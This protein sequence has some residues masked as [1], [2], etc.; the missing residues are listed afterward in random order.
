VEPARGRAARLAAAAAVFAT[1]WAARAEAFG[2][3]GHE[4][5]E[6]TAYKRLMALDAV[7]GTGTPAVSGRTVLATLIATNVLLPPPCFDRSRW[8]P[9]CDDDLRLELPLR[10]W[11]LL[12]AGAPDLVIDR[13]LG[14]QG[15]CQHF[16]ARTDDGTSAVDPRFG[17]PGD[18]VTTA[19]DR[20]VRIVGLAYDGILTN[21]T[22]ASW[23]LVGTYALIHALEDSFSA[24]HVDRDAHF[25]IVHLL[26]WTLID[27]P[28]NLFTGKRH[29]GYAAPTHHAVTDARDYE[30]LEQDGSAH[31]GKP[32]KSFLH[33]YAVPEECLTPRAL[34]AVDAVFDLL[35]MTYRIRVGPG[36]QARPA[37]ILVDSEAR[38]AWQGYLDEHFASVAA[39]AE[40]PREPFTQTK[41]R[42][43]WFLG[44]HVGAGDGAWAAGVW[45]AH[46][47]FVRPVV[48]FALVNSGGIIYSRVHGASGL[49][50]VY[51]LGLALPLVRR[52]TIG[53]S[54]IGVAVGC[55]T[56]VSDCS[57]DLTAGV[58]VLLIPLGDSTWLGLEGPRYSWID[59]RWSEVWAAVAFGWSYEDVPHPRTFAPDA[60][61]AWNPPRPDEV[62]AY[63]GA[64][65]TRTLHVIASVGSRDDD[66]Y[67]GGAVGLRRDRDAW[68][69]R[70][71]LCPELELA[72]FHGRVDATRN[73]GVV[74]VAPSLR[75]Y[76]VA[77]K[78]SLVATPALM[79]A[80]AL[81]SGKV[82]FDLGAR[83]GIAL[84]LERVELGVDSAPLSYLSDDLRHAFPLA[85][86]IGALLD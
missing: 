24:A 10:H 25:K 56:H 7:P 30:Y 29:V 81:G 32:C 77:D 67:F 47:G 53:A 31:G 75:T 79:R 20:C 8:S 22:R 54:P 62:H 80:G 19:Y 73:A 69:Q 36:G 60:A 64:R 43:D 66:A 26:S 51:T 58:G 3:V 37:S 83:A 45:G 18:L 6:A 48:P 14:Q 55:N 46:L 5:I 33:P 15:Q 74:S 11:P 84:Q 52:F 1:L 72:L 16:M 49:T 68:N 71:G 2:L 28:R 23:R 50:G 27:W 76:V 4:I 40:V 85:V 63:R 65:G 41:P 82:G 12:G 44:A 13:Q 61:A 86:R 42:T 34:A 21:P 9:G 39:K 57:V 38:G 59:R 35:V 17:V 70:S 78:I